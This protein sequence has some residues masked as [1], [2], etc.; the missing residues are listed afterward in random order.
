[1]WVF[2]S[3]FKGCV[4]FWSRERG[5]EMISLAYPPLLYM[6]LKD[7][8]AHW[9]D[10]S[11]PDHFTTFV[12]VRSIAILQGLY[13]GFALIQSERFYIVSELLLNQGSEIMKQAEPIFVAL[14]VMF[15][16]CSY[17]IGQPSSG[18]GGVT[19][20]GITNN[21]ANV[22]PVGEVGSGTKSYLGGI[23]GSTESL[24]GVK[25]G[26]VISLGGN[27]T[28]TLGGVKSGGVVLLGEGINST[29][30][31]V[32]SGEVVSLDEGVTSTLGGV[33]SGGVVSLDEGA[34]STL[35][36]VKSGGVVSLDEGASS[37][38]GGVKSGGLISLEEGAPSTLGGVKS[39]GVVSLDEDASSTLSGV[40]SG[41]VVS[42]GGVK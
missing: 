5:L 32:K 33:K 3:Y 8:H 26:E 39:G 41:G 10:D 36:G 21:G 11:S 35:G 4:E 13:H 14:I 7:P 38:L 27:V 31:G 1:M 34:S 28:S 23:N 6:C 24:G 29:L 30:G 12:L 9:R 18:I 2:D 15:I 16:W 20:L 40:K 19:S 37:T 25:S 22:Y 17:S 42:L